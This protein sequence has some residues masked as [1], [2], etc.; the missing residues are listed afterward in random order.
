MLKIVE[1]TMEQH[2]GALLRSIHLD[3]GLGS[4]VEPELLTEAFD[5]ITTGGPYECA[6]LII[7]TIPL[8]G[9]CNA[10][11]RPFTYQEIALGCPNCGSL[12]IKME[13][14]LELSITGL[15]IDEP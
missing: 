15:E 11:D 4:S 5:I 13:S 1:N 7:N 8:A 6:E 12:D 9:R 14:G 2:P 3:V 10:C